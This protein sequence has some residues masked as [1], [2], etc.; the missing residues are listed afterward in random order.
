M[1]LELKNVCKS[2]GTKQVVK[3]LSFKIDKPGV[4]GLI[5]TNGAG[6]TTTIRMI[7]GVT[8]VDSGEIT[9][10]GAPVTRKN[11]RYGYMPEERG[12]YPKIKIEDQLLYFAQLRGMSLADAKKSVNYWLHRMDIDEY[13]N[14]L[15]EKLSKGN[16]QKIQFVMTLLHDPELLFLDE[17]FSGL[18]PVNTE[19]FKDVVHELVEKGKFIVMSSHQ[20]STVEEYCEDILMLHHGKTLLHGNLADI[21]AEYPYSDLKIGFDKS[22]EE[23]LMNLSKNYGLEFEH[24]NADTLFFLLKE[25]SKPQEYISAVVNAQ[26]PVTKFELSKPTLHDIFVSKAGAKHE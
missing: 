8:N 19:L 6:K 21:K 14:V 26:I 3:N 24:K 5:G 2:Y 7:L 1:A 12:I 15:S 10:D 4:F 17:P 13:R 16:Q 20:M 25:A 23:I 9:W 18:D 11:V 22:N